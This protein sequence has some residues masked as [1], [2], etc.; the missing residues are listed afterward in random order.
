MIDEQSKDWGTTGWRLTF[1]FVVIKYLFICLGGDTDE[2][3]I[4]I[5]AHVQLTNN[6]D[7]DLHI[8]SDLPPDPILLILV[9]SDHNTPFQSPNVQ[10]S[11]YLQKIRVL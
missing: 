7:P 2:C 4:L 11:W 6:E 8:A 3:D 1:V 9:P 5:G 10:F